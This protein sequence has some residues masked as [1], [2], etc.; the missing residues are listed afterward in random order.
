MEKV[1][2]SRS[3]ASNGFNGNSAVPDDD[4]SWKRKPRTNIEVQT[5]NTNSNSFN[6]HNEP[7]R[8][9]VRERLGK[10]EPKGNSIVK[11]KP[12]LES[13]K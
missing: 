5:S 13:P 8:K 10:L 4:R 6:S 11:R 1:R 12:R 7:N 3:H 9:S 2:N